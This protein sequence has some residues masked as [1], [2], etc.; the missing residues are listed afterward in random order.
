MD[1]QRVQ[2]V[3]RKETAVVAIR[4]HR[5][6]RV[7]ADRFDAENLDIALADLQGLLTRCVPTCFGGRREYAQ[8]LVA[9]L[10][11]FAVLKR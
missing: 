4:E 8:E 6:D 10:K 1:A 9:E 5:F 11:A 2:H 3:P 7:V